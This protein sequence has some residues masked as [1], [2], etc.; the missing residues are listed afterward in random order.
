[1]NTTMGLDPFKRL[2][3][4]TGKG[5]TGKSTLSSAFCSYLKGHF[6]LDAKIIS[7]EKSDSIQNGN[8]IIYLELQSSIL[9]YLTTKLG[10]IVAKGIVKTPFFSSALQMAPGFHYLVYLGDLLQRLKQNPRLILIFDSPSSG[11]T[12]TLFQSIAQF[13]KIFQ[14][15]IL[16][17][18]IS[19]MERILQSPNFYQVHIC[20]LPDQIPMQETIELKN[21]LTLLGYS[22]ISIC[23]NRIFSSYPIL[24]E[25]PQ[26]WIHRCK[27]EQE[28]LKS[29]ESLIHHKIPF[30]PN[31]NELQPTYFEP[32]I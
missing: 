9:Q 24:P 27:Q 20:S 2:Y 21:K 32:L 17:D 14:R 18:D 25:L 31:F 4:F 11:H 16:F 3:F 8:D 10:P 7:L 13:K 29:F 23:M 22:R 30:M 28:F 6:S 12:L 5:G 26:Y 1:M 15:G 19:E